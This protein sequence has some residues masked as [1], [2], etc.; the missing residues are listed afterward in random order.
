M[1]QQADFA[2]ERFMDEFEE[3]VELNISETCCWSLS[4]NEVSQIIGQPIPDLASQRQI[5]GVI[6][7]SHELR[8]AIA[9]LYNETSF[10]AGPDQIKISGE[11]VITANGAIGA[12]FLVYYGLVGPG[13]HVVCVDP[14]YQQLKSVPE[15]FGAE[16]S[17]LPIDPANDNLP[18]IADLEALIANAK[19]PTKL[20]ILNSPHNP[21]GS[22]MPTALLK[23]FVEVAKKHD[24]YLKVDEVYRPMYFGDQADLPPS[25]VSLYA[26]GISTSSTSKAY[27]LAGLRMGWVATPDKAAR[28]ACLSRRDY[29]MISTGVLADTVSTWALRGYK[30]LIAYNTA[31]CQRVL[32]HLDSWVSSSNGAVSYVKPTGGTT[33]FLKIEGVPDNDTMR[34]CR[35]FI[36]AKSTLIVPG[37]TFDRPGYVRVGFGNDLEVM[38]QGLERLKEYLVKKKYVPNP[39]GSA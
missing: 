14:V 39:W 7:G 19:N 29:N 17:L 21:S 26:K 8:G 27:G 23:E 3:V 33:T 35:E 28:L 37:E 25:I 15:M 30:P 9:D 22:V 31:Q 2:I 16:V 20:I 12:N 36:A 38:K 18:R 1:V 32:A 11:D 5:Y 24:A 34:F 4:L 6:S 10:N 13:D